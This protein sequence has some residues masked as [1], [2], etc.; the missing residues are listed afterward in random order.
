MDVG[1]WLLEYRAK[2]DRAEA[3]WLERLA[4]FDREGAWAVDG[5]LSC[6]SW[7]VWRLRIARATAFEKVRVAHELV[8]RPVVADAFR[9]GDLSY[10]EVRIIT[11]IK[12]P[13]PEVDRA[14]VEVATSSGR[15]IADLEV[16]PERRVV[17]M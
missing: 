6:V 9:A 14:L 16:C 17:T 1:E 13:D 11:R 8:R 4:Q 12:W 5:Q 2:M 10:S 7:L 3:L 15:S